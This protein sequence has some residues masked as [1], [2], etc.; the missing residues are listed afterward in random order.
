VTLSVRVGRKHLGTTTVGI[1][2]YRTKAAG[3]PHIV[4]VVK[5][6]SDM[7]VTEKSTRDMRARE[8]KLLDEKAEW[9][10]ERKSPVQ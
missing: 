6:A 9:L 10:C 8:G 5:K 7:V 4:G 3:K 2:V 1:K